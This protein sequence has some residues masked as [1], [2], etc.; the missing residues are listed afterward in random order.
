MA[1]MTS[2]IS[3]SDAD[4]AYERLHP[5]IRGWI[6]SQGWKSLR[7]VQVR[8][9]NAILDGK[10]DVLISAST[11]SGK[12]E[13]V[14]LPIL[15]SVA[16]RKRPGLS[17][18][19]VSPLKALINDQFV[20]LDQ[21]CDDMEI[22]IVRWHGDS[23]QS[24]KAKFAKEA[25]GI[26]LITPESIEAMFVRHPD[27]I[28]S[29]LT[30]LDFIVI[31]EVHAF[32]Q[33]AR[34]LHLGSLLKRIAAV[35]KKPARRVGLS[36]TIGDLSL[37]AAWLRPDDSASVYMLDDPGSGL[38][39]MLQIRGYVDKSPKRPA[40][41]D[42]AETPEPKRRDDGASDDERPEEVPAIAIDEICNHLFEMLRSSNSRGANN[43]VFGGSRRMVEIVAD[44]LRSKSE[45]DGVPN[46]FFPHHGN[47]SKELREDL[48]RRLKAGDLPTTAVCTTTL[49]LGIDIGSVKTVA[50]IGS[51]RSISSLRQRLGRTGRREG[52]PSILRIYAIEP[53]LDDKSSFVDELRPDVVRA[54]ASIRLLAQ[55]FSEP[56]STSEALATGLLHQTLS[57][58][59]ERG[60][61]R[62]DVA[63]SLLSG[64]GPFSSVQP[65]DYIELLRHAK[66]LKIVEQ[67]PDGLLMLRELGEQLVQARDFYPLFQVTQEWRLVLGSKPLGTIPLSNP[68]AVDNLVLF[69]GRRWKI[70]AVDEKAHVIEV[71]PHRGGQVP[72]FEN[73]SGEEVHTRLIV[74][75]RTVYESEDV[76]PFLDAAA[77]ELLAQGRDAY[78]R[79]GLARQ[80]VLNMGGN[81][82]LFPWI[83]TSTVAALCV[84]LAGFGVKSEDNGVGITVPGGINDAMD[85]LAKLASFTKDD[86]AAVENSLVAVCTAKYDEFVPEALLRRFWGRRNAG[87]IEQIPDIARGLLNSSEQI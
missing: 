78:R 36:A 17:A 81:A 21:L 71:E 67:A 86:L 8:A 38:D 69:A 28:Q 70:I 63:F 26:A 6:R 66:T 32:M 10:G 25:R 79:A 7:P 83:G 3:S 49:E 30:S 60:G 15:T 5:K 20:R 34:G 39:L 44:A 37:A 43:L 40:R 48:E 57:M 51:P 80:N 61:V 68:V 47:L 76:P 84:A 74:E 31:D 41:G 52:E 9:A 12:T 23:S 62:A 64:P 22:P 16:D 4:R 54:V 73:P 46:E 58:I 14:F 87:V 35:S 65:K 75:M 24:A 11:A 59:A 29:L 55:K 53:E 56:P 72:K 33:G 27:R 13:A 82:L 42:A 2:S 1:A 45:A 77:R 50:Q 19:Y 85:A 18:L